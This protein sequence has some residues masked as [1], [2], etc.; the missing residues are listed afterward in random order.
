[1]FAELKDNLYICMVA[2]TNKTSD[3]DMDLSIIVPVY[4][5]E[6]YIRSC[7]LSLFKQ[8]LEDNR[9]EVI[10]VNDGTTDKSMEMVEDTISQHPNIIVI[11]QENQGLSVAR[12]NGIAQAKGKY[13]LFAD[14]D[15]LLVDNSI[16]PLLD[17]AIGYHADLVVA[18]F[19]KF[20]DEK[21]FQKPSLDNKDI[22]FEEMN[23]EDLLLELNPRNCF[24]W[25]T[26]Y[27]KEFLVD[28]HI[29]FIPNIYYEDVPFT[30]ECYMKANRC[31]KTSWPIYL[32]RTRSGSITY[33]FTTKNAD[34]FI[35]ATAKTWNLMYEN[36]LSQKSKYR[37]EENVYILC[38]TII[39]H[40]LHC[41][42]DATQRKMIVDLIISRIPTLNFNHNIRQKATSFMLKHIP[43][44]FIN[45]YYIYSRVFWRR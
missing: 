14:S 11:N 24:V 23:G 4:N 20:D 44:T 2:T 41:I 17:K 10:I 43:H 34:H 27:R 33:T 19:I 30:H 35:T 32:Y 29:N 6:K 25:R 13:I 38:S 12:N 28:N 21:T 16:C 22:V 36:K 31:L 15:D 39:Y 1:M 45:F 26:I 5:V 37:L 7:I 18:D 9:F 42:K 3:K 40:T 8:G